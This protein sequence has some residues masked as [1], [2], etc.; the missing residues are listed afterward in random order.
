MNLATD[1]LDLA[2]SIAAHVRESSG[3]LPK[4]QARG[5]R[6]EDPDCAQVSMNLLDVGVTP[7]WRVY[8]AVRDEAAAAGVDVLESELIGLAPL[9]AF[10]DVADHAGVPA[11]LPAE[12]RLR[13]AGAWMRLRG[14]DPSMALE[15]RVAAAMAAE[16]GDGARRLR[17]PGR[18]WRAR[19]GPR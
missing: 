14:A 3:G 15:L 4:V 19:G 1:D 9:R 6:L 17:R 12:E 8:E 11:D 18:R 2:K 13:A 16:A 10:T 7:M 5:F